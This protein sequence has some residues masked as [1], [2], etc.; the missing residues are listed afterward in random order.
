M[1]ID[2]WY[3]YNRYDKLPELTECILNCSSCNPFKCSHFLDGFGITCSNAREKK[4]TNY[5]YF[6]DLSSGDEII[7]YWQEVSFIKSKIVKLSIQ[8]TLF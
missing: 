7:E 1:N 3:L 2:E 6:P 5:Y 8:L 4:M